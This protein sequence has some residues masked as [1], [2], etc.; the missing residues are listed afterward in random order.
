MVA[1][2]AGWDVLVIMIV[3]GCAPVVADMVPVAEAS[4]MKRLRS[5][6]SY[7]TVIAC[8]HMVR[9]PSMLVVARS[10]LFARARSV[11]A[12]LDSGYVLMQPAKI[13]ERTG[14]TPWIVVRV[15]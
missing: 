3:V 15:V 8:A 10:V 13:T 12:G 1:D 14:L 6:F 5:S 2:D 4:V 11:V 9:G 7:A